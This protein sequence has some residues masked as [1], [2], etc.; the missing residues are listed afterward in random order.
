VL[1]GIAAS[2]LAGCASN[3]ALD[4]LLGAIPDT[5]GRNT[6]LIQVINQTGSA[7]EIELAI[8]GSIA[9]A[10]CS[11][12]AQVC[13]E[14]LAECPNSVSILTQRV[15][16]EDGTIVQ[17]RS[18]EGID[19]FTFTREDFSCGSVILVELEATGLQVIIIPP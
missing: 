8:D 3:A 12:G 11:S 13:R 14:P 18:Y 7:S 9:T 15:L 4:A 16:A 5:S 10:S 19:N 2:M 1:A 17:E 6:L